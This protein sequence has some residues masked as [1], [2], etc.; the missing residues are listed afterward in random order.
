MNMRVCTRVG[1]PGLGGFLSLSHTCLPQPVYQL[2]GNISLTSFSL[3][4]LLVNLLSRETSANPGFTAKAEAG[5]TLVW[6]TPMPSGRTTKYKQKD[7]NNV[8]RL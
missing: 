8:N 4:A 7:I 2:P 1:T 5:L 6:L 3:L